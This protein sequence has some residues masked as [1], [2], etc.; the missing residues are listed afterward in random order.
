[1]RPIG[2]HRP[3]ACLP[4]SIAGMA[5]FARGARGWT[6]V[7]CLVLAMCWLPARTL[8]EAPAVPEAP[9]RSARPVPPAPLSSP[10]YPELL[11]QG[12]GTLPGERPLPRGLTDGPEAEQC[13]E[14]GVPW[15]EDSPRLWHPGDALRRR[16]GRGGDLP[17]RPPEAARPLLRESWLF[18]PFS[19]GAFVGASYG[20]ELVDDW[21]SQRMGNW[22]GFRFGWDFHPYWGCDVRLAFG[23]LEVHDSLRAIAAQ[24]AAD[25]AA[26]LDPNDPLRRRFDGGRDSDLRLVLDFNLL[27]YPLGDAAWRPYLSIGAGSARI[28]FLDRLSYYWQSGAVT[29]PVGVG[30]KYRWQDWLATRVELTD[31]I[32]FPSGGINRL[33]EFSLTAGVEFRFGGSCKGYWP[34]NPGLSYW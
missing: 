6:A 30:V 22:G 17:P 23:H 27:Y 20:S 32:V 10:G 12:E 33:H 31:T 28:E 1:M 8:A 11:G 9:P 34:W 18:R 4:A 25:D 2:R 7:G 3:A 13:P 5:G 26:G 21:I 15:A 24:N 29:L 16:L 14:C 19:L